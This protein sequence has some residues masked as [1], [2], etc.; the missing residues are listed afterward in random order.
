MSTR[1]TKVST[2]IGRKFAKATL[3]KFTGGEIVMPSVKAG[4]GKKW[5]MCI[6]G[7][8]SDF[9]TATNKHSYYRCAR[10]RKQAWFRSDQL[11]QVAV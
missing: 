6:D 1:R 5:I 2:M 10:G 3:R 8:E 11:T 9:H 4:M 7:H